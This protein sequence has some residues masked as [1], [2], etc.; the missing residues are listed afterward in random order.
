MSTRDAPNQGQPLTRRRWFIGGISLAGL[1]LLAACSSSAPAAAPTTASTSAAPTAASAA[2]TASSA[3]AASAPSPTPATTSSTSSTPAAAPTSGTAPTPAATPAPQAASG[4]APA[5]TTEIIWTSW[6]TD[7]YGMFRVQEQVNDFTKLHPEIKVTLRNV[8]SSGYMDKLLADLAGGVGP[9][10]FRIGLDQFPP[11]VRQK[12]VIELDPLFKAEPNSLLGGKDLKPG[13][14]DLFRYGGKLYNF[15]IGLDMPAFFVNKTLFDAAKVPYPPSDYASGSWTFPA[16]A[17]MAK[18]LTKMEGNR[19]VQFGVSIPSTGDWQSLEGTVIANGGHLLSEDLKEFTWNTPPALDALQ[20]LADLRNRL[21]VAPTPGQAQ[22]GAFNFVG[23]R[24]A[25]AF[26]EVSQASY[27]TQDVKDKF[28][29]DMVPWPQWPNQSQVTLLDP[30]SEALNQAT[31]QRDAAWT[32]Y[33]W[34]VGPGGQLVDAQWGWGL[35]IYYSLDPQ[36]NSRIAQ[37]KKNVKPG[38]D[39]PKYL[40]KDFPLANPRFGEAWDQIT[41]G[42]DNAWLGKEPV[43]DAIN[44]IKPAID[45]LLQQGVAELGQM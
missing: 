22:G 14:V 33:Y 29:W 36:Y 1:G 23:G 20:F 25:L 11:L 38:I 44:R 37:F 3:S 10:M 45:K 43:K 7:T 6:A 2:P 41:S 28:N 27:R 13:V 19:A 9:D 34:R 35:P 12:Q 21:K 24:L 40:S 8:P 16:M 5:G 17:E 15:P 39:G 42:L 26:T 32:F 31:K 4:A 18:K 30:S